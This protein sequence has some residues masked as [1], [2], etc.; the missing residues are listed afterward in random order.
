MRANIPQKKNAGYRNQNN[1]IKPNKKKGKK[2]KRNSESNQLIRSIECP[3]CNEI[4]R[5]KIYQCTHGHLICENCKKKLPRHKNNDNNN[6][7]NNNIKVCLCPQCRIPMENEIR[8]LALENLR[9]QCISLP[10][11]YKLH[12]CEE[13]FLSPELTKHEK[14]C[15]YRPLPCG[16]LKCDWKG[17]IKEY[18][19]HLIKAH[20]LIKQNRNEYAQVLKNSK[21][22]NYPYWRFLHQCYGSEFFVR[23][24]RLTN[25]NLLVTCQCLDENYH[26]FQVDVQLTNPDSKECN[27]FRSSQPVA[28][29]RST[30][31]HLAANGPA[32]LIPTYIIFPKSQF[33]PLDLRVGF[34]FHIKKKGIDS[35]FSKINGCLN[36]SSSSS[37]GRVQSLN[38]GPVIEIL[39]D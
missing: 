5:K 14:E 34:S 38:T 11:S 23:L 12:G 32:V 31:V 21:G 10:C 15:Y 3:I 1:G 17:S 16:E 39:D 22:Y 26:Q 4:M 13:S 8:N 9:N 28:D 35:K 7:N 29:I 27:F 25:G 24:K 30:E 33:N 19:D 6:N 36:R 20:S 37:A 2:R 18:G